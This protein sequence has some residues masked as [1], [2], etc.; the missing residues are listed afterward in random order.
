VHYNFS[1]HTCLLCLGL[2]GER[3][4]VESFTP[5]PEAKQAPGADAEIVLHCREAV[6]G[7]VIPLSLRHSKHQALTLMLAAH[8][9]PPPPLWH[10]VATPSTIRNSTTSPIPHVRAT[11]HLLQSLLWVYLQHA[12]ATPSA[13]RN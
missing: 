1:I 4:F 8:R 10:A 2:R 7:C 9:S 5:E 3:L 12:V 13:I 11:A 6:C